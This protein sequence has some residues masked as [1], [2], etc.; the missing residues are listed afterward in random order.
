[1]CNTSSRSKTNRDISEVEEISVCQGTRHASIDLCCLSSDQ[2][3]AGRI[4]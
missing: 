2:H 4:R 3:G 1:V